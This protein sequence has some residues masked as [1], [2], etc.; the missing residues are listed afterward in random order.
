MCRL[1]GREVCNECFHTVEELTKPDDPDDTAD[2]LT[3]RRKLREKHA[4]SNPFFL[5]CLKR[6]EHTLS[7]FS[8]VTRF[9]L[10]ELNRAI[11]EMESILNN[12]ESTGIRSETP[13]QE[14]RIPFDVTA[15]FPDPLTSPVYDDFTPENTPVHVASIP[16][17]RSQ[18]IPAS[19]YDPPPSKHPSNS[20]FSS[21]WARGIPLLV[22]DVLPR[23]RVTWSPEYF[24]EKYGDQNC[25][26]VE[27]QTDQ[28]QRVTIK[29]FF[30]WFGEYENRTDCWKLKV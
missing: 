7:E 11:D 24:M 18:I 22:K 27:C 16:T 12:V 8:P 21:L 10:S 26:I 17:H 19:Y 15:S 2:E 20:S 9:A 3:A 6:N 28:N 13:P 1:C 25:I 30:E 5:S 14:D 4:H 29:K 23:F